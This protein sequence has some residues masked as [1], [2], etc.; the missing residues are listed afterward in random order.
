[1]PTAAELND[2]R[3]R[4]ELLALLEQQLETAQRE[5]AAISTLDY[6]PAHELI[7]AR[8]EIAEARITLSQ[9]ELHDRRASRR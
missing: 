1:M 9:L 6:P 3:R 5:L 4:R 8:T 7:I 2:R